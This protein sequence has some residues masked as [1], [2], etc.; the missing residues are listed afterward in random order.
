MAAQLTQK[1]QAR[2][3]VLYKR[4]DQIADIAHR[5]HCTERT[6]HYHAKR[7]NWVHGED[8]RKYVKELAVNEEV[9]TLQEGL[10]QAEG[11]RDNYLRKINMLEG[12]MTATLRALGQTPEEI[13][14][15]PKAEADRVFSILKNL[16]ISSEISQMHYEAS[17]KALGLDQIHAEDEEGDVLPIKIN[18]TKAIRAVSDNTE[19]GDDNASASNDKKS[20]K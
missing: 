4:G 8:K 7:N 2:M 13:R 20:E 17:R 5:L 15:I 19:E 12:M 3:E 16:K 10:K 11:L 14:N 9:S 18:V 6:I 1:E